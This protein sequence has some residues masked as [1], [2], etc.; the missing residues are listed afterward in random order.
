[1]FDLSKPFALIEKEGI[2]TAYHGSLYKVNRIEEI[3]TVGEDNNAERVFVLPYNA[4]RERGFEARGDE[5]ILVLAVETSFILSRD[6]LPDNTI[7]IDGEITPSISDS[8]YAELIDRFQKRAIEQGECAQA[9]LSRRFSGCIKDFSLQTVL[10]LYKKLLN[11]PGHY[12]TVLFSYGEGVLIAGTPESHLVLTADESTMTPIAGT[13][14]KENGGSLIDFLNDPKEIN[15]LFQVVDEEMKMMAIICPQGGEIHGPYL[16]EVGAVIHTEYKLTGAR[17]MRAME[18][19]RQSLHA[20]TVVGS[21][22]ESA[23]RQI[24]HYE[25]DSR[26]YYAGE[27]GLYRPATDELDCAILIRGAEIQKDG[28]FH[29]QA[30]GGIVRDSI[31]A[32]EVLE[33]RAKANGMLNILTGRA[34]NSVMLDKTYRNWIMPVLQERNK[35]LSRF[36]QSEQDKVQMRELNGC[37]ITIINNEDD[38]AYMIAHM[39]R[40]LCGPDVEVVDTFAFDP[41][42]D[43]SDLV[44]LGPGPGDPTDKTH[45]RMQ[46]LQDIIQNLMA[47]KQSLLGICLGHQALAV[48]Q[49]LAVT[50]QQ[51]SSQ[52]MPKKVMIQGQERILAFYNSFSPLSTQDRLDINFDRDSD[53][54][55]IAMRGNHFVGYQFHPES[56]MSLDGCAMI[57]DALAYLGV[58]A[59]KGL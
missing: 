23:A 4:I 29:V 8:D 12:M 44:V 21:P 40:R 25:S 31:P 37:R 19:L 45:P 3:E 35:H 36:W 34:K 32:Q 43:Q 28:T 41:V 9:T 5:P 22:L 39:L 7:E 59:Q 16:R 54:R 11:Q 58:T 10:S 13:Y 56:V 42:T 2:I 18:V 47:K 38:F 46:R 26:R 57:K 53:S 49:G 52:G 30:G 1:M 48:A 51:Q 14:R 24:A 20:P 55:I 6:D 27:I 15:E 50:R 17:G 33:S